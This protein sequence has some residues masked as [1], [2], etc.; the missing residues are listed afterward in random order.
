MKI[1][2]VEA[3]LMSYPL[4]EPMRLPFWN[5]D[6]T[7]VKRDAM[8]LRVKTDTGL[9]GYAPGPAPERAQKEIHGAIRSD[10]KSV[11]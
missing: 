5:G 11:V 10:R 4:P 3:F 9:T 1:T 8:L 2:S 7:I 6:R